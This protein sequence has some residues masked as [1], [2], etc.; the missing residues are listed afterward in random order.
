MGSLLIEEYIYYRNSV[1]RKLKY[2][3]KGN[4]NRIVASEIALEILKLKI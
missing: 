4:E 1:V 3:R 2:H